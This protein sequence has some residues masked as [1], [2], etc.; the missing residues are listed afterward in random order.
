[1]IH[2]ISQ[3]MNAGNEQKVFERIGTLEIQNDDSG[4]VN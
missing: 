2:T 4:Q 1:L 3:S